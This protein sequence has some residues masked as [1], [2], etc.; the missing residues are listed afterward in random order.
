VARRSLRRVEGGWGWKFDRLVFAQFA[1]G[2]R[3]VALPYLSEVRCRLALLRSEHGLVTEDIGADMYEQLGRVAPVIEIAGPA[4]TP[5]STSRSCCSPPCARWSPTGITRASRRTDSP[6][7][8]P[9]GTPR[10]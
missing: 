3:S 4:T 2:M 8:P 7:S 5:C 1:A 6:L 9:T 10:Q